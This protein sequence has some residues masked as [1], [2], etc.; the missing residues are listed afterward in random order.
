MSNNNQ[1][2]NNL[3]EEA[4]EGGSKMKHSSSASSFSSIMTN[5][6]IS[7][8]SSP[9]Q[10]QS[11]SSDNKYNISNVLKHIYQIKYNK[12]NQIQAPTSA[13]NISANASSQSLIEAVNLNA[14]AHGSKQFWMPDDQVKECYECNDKFTTFRRKH[15]NNILD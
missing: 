15:V 10:T 5:E 3:F 11:K 6:D 2:E 13:S 14:S 1:S 12:T 4:N 8:A 9:N 7:S